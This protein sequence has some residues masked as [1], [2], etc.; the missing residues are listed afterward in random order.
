MSNVHPATTDLYIH[1][2]VYTIHGLL[3]AV[4]VLFTGQSLVGA[5]SFL[6]Q[7]F[8]DSAGQ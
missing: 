7:I 8:P 4:L 1:V 5:S 6:R 2:H 3:V